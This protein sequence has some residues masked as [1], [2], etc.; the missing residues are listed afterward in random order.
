MNKFSITLADDEE[1]V[2]VDIIDLE[3]KNSVN[4]IPWITLT[5]L[6]ENIRDLEFD[7]VKVNSILA[8]I[9]HVNDQL[10]KKIDSPNDLLDSR[11]AN[12]NEKF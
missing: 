8:D 3:I 11:D 7:I 10:A 5:L 2:Q 4:D 9:G 6:E 1:P 12:F